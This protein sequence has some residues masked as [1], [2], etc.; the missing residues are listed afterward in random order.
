[1]TASRIAVAQYI[2]FLTRKGEDLDPVDAR[3]Y[4]NFHVAQSRTWQGHTYLFAPFAIG[5][6]A[7]GSA[8]SNISSDLVLPANLMSGA[9]MFEAAKKRF[10]LEVKTVLLEEIVGTPLRW[11][12]ISTLA[13]QVWVATQFAYTDDVPDDLEGNAVVALSL[14]SPLNAVG[15][16]AP[17]VRLRSRWVGSL[18]ATGRLVF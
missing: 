1:M 14:S 15:S 2:R 3:A 9:A 6:E 5:G 8:E 7:S 13:T 11:T 17:N 16:T 12:E 10:M 18:P 4:Q